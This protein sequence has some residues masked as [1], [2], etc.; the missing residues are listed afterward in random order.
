MATRT[1]FMWK[2]ESRRA[3]TIDGAFFPPIG[4]ELNINMRHFI[5]VGLPEMYIE[6][7]DDS[8]ESDIEIYIPVK[9][10]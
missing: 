7:T 2:D 5:V 8:T 1:A 10:N 6:T 4:T 9:R 3:A